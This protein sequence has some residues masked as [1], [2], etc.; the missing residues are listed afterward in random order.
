MRRISLGL[1]AAAAV[2]LLSGCYESKYD[3]I[4][5]HA[6]A[7]T[8]ADTFLTFRDATY[9]ARKAGAASIVCAATKPSSI[10]S[11]CDSPTEIKLE[12]TAWGNYI[13]QTKALSTYHYALWYRGRDELAR[14]CFMP[15]GEDIVGFGASAI[16]APDHKPHSPYDHNRR[17]QDLR[18][19]LAG[20][21]QKEIHSRDEL[22]AI[23]SAYE[24]TVLAIVEPICFGDHLRVTSPVDLVI[25]GDNRNLPDL[26]P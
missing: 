11:S 6:R 15:L 10:N 22:L 14:D 12:R 9:F 13:V 17:F 26:Q 5:S 23:V 2:V 4:A 19:A 8:K 3:L 24:S 1:V 18:A 16:M 21:D 7:V 20:Y 25:A